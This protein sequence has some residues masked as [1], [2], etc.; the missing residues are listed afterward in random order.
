MHLHRAYKFT[1]VDIR[2]A[3]ANLVHAIS[4]HDLD[5]EPN[6]FSAEARQNNLIK[7]ITLRVITL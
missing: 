5:F 4:S 3:S 2:N 1:L 6:S 7:N